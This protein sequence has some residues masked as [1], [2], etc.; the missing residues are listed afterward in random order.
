MSGDKKPDRFT[1]PL[2]YAFRAAF[3]EHDAKKPL[4]LKDETGERIIPS[5][6]I[7]PRNIVNQTALKEELGEDLASLLNTV[8]MESCEDLSPYKHVTRSI[9][10]YWLFDL[11]AISIDDSAA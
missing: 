9:L 10:N 11:A 4:D 1:P 6:R 7:S 5:R 8:N 3:R 2:M